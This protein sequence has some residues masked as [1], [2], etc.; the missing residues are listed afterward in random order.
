MKDPIVALT[1][2]RHIQKWTTHVGLFHLL[3]ATAISHGEPGGHWPAAPQR[4]SRWTEQRYFSGYETT[5]PKTS[6]FC[7]WRSCSHA[8]DGHPAIIPAQQLLALSLDSVF[9]IIGSCFLSKQSPWQTTQMFPPLLHHSSSMNYEVLQLQ[10]SFSWPRKRPS[11]VGIWD[12]AF[13]ASLRGCQHVPV[14]LW[15]CEYKGQSSLPAWLKQPWFMQSTG[16]TINRFVTTQHKPVTRGSWGWV[17]DRC[18]AEFIIHIC[19]M[20]QQAAYLKWQGWGEPEQSTFP[21]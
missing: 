19:I 9:F 21:F 3:Q 15:C 6:T 16:A 10:H 4:S 1:P 13:H 5:K 11:A 7:S 20:K 14:L 12:T 2:L 18:S 17:Q 8:Q